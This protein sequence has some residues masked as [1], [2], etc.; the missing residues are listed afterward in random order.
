MKKFLPKSASNP[1]GFT[2]VELLVVV[3]IIAILAVIGLTIF[4]GL[5][6]N[7]RDAKRRADVEAISKALETAYNNSTAQ[8]PIVT[9]AMF[10]SGVIP[11]DPL[12]GS[13][14]GV[15][16]AVAATYNVCA[17]LE[18]DG[19]APGDLSPNDFCITQQQ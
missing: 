6:K 12:G 11:T 18:N 1:S 5:Q 10:S 4:T 8:Y 16:V 14:S 2:L 17:D 13:Y 7:A 9:V 15:P 3:S 19:R